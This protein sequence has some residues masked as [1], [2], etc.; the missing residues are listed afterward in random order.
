VEELGERVVEPAAR[1]KAASRTL[2]DWLLD[3]HLERT[4]TELNVIALERELERRGLAASRPQR[5]PAVAF[6]DVSGYTRLTAERGDEL[7]VRMAVRLGELADDA[8]RRHG[9][10]VVKLLGD[11]VL[12]L[13][14]DACAA[15]RAS[16][17]LA[18]AM[19]AAELPPAHGGV[20]AGPVI[21]RDGD[22]YGTTVNTASRVAGH[23]SAGVILVTGAVVGEC[24]ADDGLAFEPHGS[25]QLKGLAEPVL[26]YEV[27]TAGGQRRPGQRS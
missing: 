12:L 8:A 24:G 25:A 7:G 27:R 22:V 20:H 15:V 18:E 19:A 5:P 3:R 1:V 10:R 4:M 11:G 26:L 17:D 21:E 13:F 14:A 23:A 16:L 9:G 6:V 2:M